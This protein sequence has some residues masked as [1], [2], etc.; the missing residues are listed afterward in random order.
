LRIESGKAWRY[1]CFSGRFPFDLISRNALIRGFYQ[2]NFL[3]GPGSPEIVFPV[4]MGIVV[5]F[6]SLRYNVVLP[7]SSSV[8]PQIH[9]LKRTQK[10]IA[11]P[12]IPK[13]NLLAFLQLVPQVLG[14]IQSLHSNVINTDNYNDTGMQP[15]PHQDCQTHRP[16]YPSYA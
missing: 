2:V 11:D 5:V 3:L 1:R 13:V 15:S 7:E 14:V 8:C 9:G 10:G 4:V 6:K 12:I 16:C